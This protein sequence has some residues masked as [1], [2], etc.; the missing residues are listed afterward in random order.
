MEQN[1]HDLIMSFDVEYFMTKLGWYF[2]DKPSEIVDFNDESGLTKE[3]RIWSKH[4]DTLDFIKEKIPQYKEITMTRHQYN[5][6]K[7]ILGQKPIVKEIE[8]EL[9]FIPIADKLKFYNLKRKEVFNRIEI[10]MF[11]TWVYGTDIFPWITNMM[12][13]S[14]LIGFLND[15]IAYQWLE[16]KTKESH[17]DTKEQTKISKIKRGLELSAK[18]KVMILKYLGVFNSPIFKHIPTEKDR[19]KLLSA[20]FG[21]ASTDNLKGYL[22]DAKLDKTE[23][24]LKKFIETYLSKL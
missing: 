15:V 11:D 9:E 14:T 12:Q 22:S 17:V 19:V 8:N 16:N 20:L 13:I 18:D 2:M 21:G 23:I 6:V 4:A 24:D 1:K 7:E 10:K 3:Y 5:M